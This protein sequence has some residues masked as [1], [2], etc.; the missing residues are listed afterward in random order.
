VGIMN[1]IVQR[2]MKKEAV[3]LS[4]E[5]RKLYDNTRLKM[6]NVSEKEIVLNMVFSAESLST[7][8][9]ES[10]NRIESCC[11][12]VNG[13]CYM[14]ALDAGV[15][16]KWMNLRSLQF[17]AY[18]DRELLS[19]GFPKQSLQQKEA[20]LIVMELALEGWQEVTGDL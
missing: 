3:R 5:A 20:I 2:S 1:T 13:L 14:L 10:R 7:L 19:V 12:T 16:R 6:G 9:L 18:M 15:F 8:P 17:T 4:K 11:E